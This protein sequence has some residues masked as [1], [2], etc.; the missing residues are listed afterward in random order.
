ME[1]V[2]WQIGP[3]CVLFSSSPSREL[4]RQSAARMISFQNAQIRS[5][6]KTSRVKLLDA[7]RIAALIRRMRRSVVL[8]AVYLVLQ[9]S[10]TC[11]LAQYCCFGAHDTL[12]TCPA[13]GIPNHSFWLKACPIS[14]V[15][16]YGE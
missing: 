3:L 6:R 12:A 13:S 7:T 8:D 11:K 10:L 15:Y 9:V 1:I 16:A 2:P 4:T 5:R 14:Y